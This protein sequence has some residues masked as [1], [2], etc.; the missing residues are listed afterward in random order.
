MVIVGRGFLRHFAYLSNKIVVN[1]EV[2]RFDFLTLGE[3]PIC[4]RPHAY[5]LGWTK[6]MLGGKDR[7]CL[8]YSPPLKN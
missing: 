5:E 7:S 1:P 4:S 3:R 6:L 8:L 2:A